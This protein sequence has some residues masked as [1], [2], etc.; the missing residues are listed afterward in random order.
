MALR[1]PDDDLLQIRDP[2]Q[3]PL[4]QRLYADWFGGAPGSQGARALLHTQYHAI[5]APGADTEGAPSA[6]AIKW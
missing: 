1:G 4:L 5:S 3:G 6:L 2:L